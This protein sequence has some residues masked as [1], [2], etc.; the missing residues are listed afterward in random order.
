MLTINIFAGGIPTASDKIKALEDAGVM[1]AV[2]P[3]KIGDLTRALLER[4]GLIPVEEEQRKD[5]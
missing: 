5:W 4:E 3:G 1:I 2:H